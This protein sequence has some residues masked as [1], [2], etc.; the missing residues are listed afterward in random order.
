MAYVN[1]VVFP[2]GDPVHSE[3][4]LILSANRR[5]NHCPFWFAIEANLK[6]K[7]DGPIV[8]YYEAVTPEEGIRRYQNY[9]IANPG[10]RAK[11]FYDKND[12]EMIQKYESLLYDRRTS[13]VIYY[14]TD[15]ESGLE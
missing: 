6:E 15:W 2:I 7:W 8:D 11:Y 10:L 1:D 12:V 13:M 9:I 3:L 4:D 5:I 14:K